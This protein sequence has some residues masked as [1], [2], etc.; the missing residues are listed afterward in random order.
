MATL[1]LTGGERA[2]VV[3][4][5]L[6]AASAATQAPSAPTHAATAMPLPDPS[7][8]NLAERQVDYLCRN[9]IFTYGE[10]GAGLRLA[11]HDRQPDRAVGG[12]DAA[13]A[14]PA[15]LLLAEAQGGSGA[16]PGRSSRRPRRCRFGLPLWWR[17]ATVS[18][19]M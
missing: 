9:A 8:R 11:P 15:D 6:G 3:G 16:R 18:W 7:G 10:L 17:R 1:T 12:G 13:A 4:V 5:L 2:R 19:P 14:D